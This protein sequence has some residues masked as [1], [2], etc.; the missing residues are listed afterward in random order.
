[1][2]LPRDPDAR[3]V[4]YVLALVLLAGALLAP[5]AF[6]RTTTLAGALGFAVVARVREVSP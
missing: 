6:A 2:T 1:M 4:C 3:A 5:D